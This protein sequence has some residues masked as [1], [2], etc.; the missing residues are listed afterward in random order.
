MKSLILVLLMSVS[1]FA[2][3]PFAE[4]TLKPAPP[5]YS[6]S[7]IWTDTSLAKWFAERHVMALGT[8]PNLALTISKMKSVN[9]DIKVALY[10]TFVPDAAD[11]VIYKNIAQTLGIDFEKCI[12]RTGPNVGDSVRVRVNDNGTSGFARYVT[13]KGGNNILLQPGYTNTQTRFVWDFREPAVGDLLG[14]RWKQ[15]ADAAGCKIVIV[16]EETISGFT[17]MAPAGNYPIHYPFRYVSLFTAGSPYSGVNRPWGTFDLPPSRGGDA[18]NT[19]SYEDIR[20]SL[21]LARNGWMARA[22]VRLGDVMYLPNFAAIPTNMGTY[23]NF[24]NEGRHCAVLCGAYIMGEYSYFYP[25]A[26][27][28]ESNCNAAIRA[29]YSV[30]DSAVNFFVMWIRMGQFDL[31]SGIS[32]DQSQFNGLGF[33]LETIFPGNTSYYHSFCRQNGQTEFSASTLNGVYAE[34]KNILWDDAFALRYGKPTLVRDTAQKGSDPAGQTYTLHK[35]NLLKEDN[36]ISTVV[37]G[38]YARGTNVSPSTSVNVNLGGSYFEV[39]PNAAFSSAP[40]TST[41]VKNAQ[42]RVFVA[43]TIYAKGETSIPQP[44]E[45]L[46]TLHIKGWF[47]KDSSFNVIIKKEN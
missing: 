35:F 30:K 13:T 10:V 37:V 19:H 15:L 12:I 41:T 5:T 28:S 16:D 36:S 20:D 39:L 25:G 45:L 43:D 42:F 18:D 34:D 31:A 26:D 7:W 9:P 6:G 46:D 44:P 11:T 22:R 3:P 32:Y 40:V 2:L 8:G 23:S 47:V 21:R 4:R 1:S 27:G 38:R 33:G 14:T 29:S 24:E 17:N